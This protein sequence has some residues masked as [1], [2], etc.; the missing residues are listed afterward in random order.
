MAS[1]KDTLF[2]TQEISTQTPILLIDASGSTMF[3]KFDNVIILDK[4]KEIIKNNLP[5][6]QFRIIWWNSNTDNSNNSKFTNGLCIIPFIVKKSTLDQTFA[7]IKPSIS[8]SCLTFPH[9][10]FTSIPNDWISSTNQ[11]KVYFITD[12]EMGYGNISYSELNSL[13][14]NLSNSI[15]NLFEKYNTVQ[16]TI[17]T[18]EP[19]NTNFT[20]IESL[21]SAAGCDVY[22]VIMNNKLTNYV[23]KFVSYTPNNLNGFVHINKNIPP[24]GH[25]PYEDKYFSELRVGDFIK[26]L[27]DKIILNKTSDDELLKIVQLLSTTI[28]YL[29]K[30]KPKNVKNDIV[31]TFCNLFYDTSLDIMLVKFIVSDSVTKESEGSANV[32]ASYRAKLQDLYKQATQLLLTD[33][34]KS[35]G[36]NEHFITLPIMNNANNMSNNTNNNMK[37]ISGHCRMV[38][39]Q[40]T[41]NNQT[42]PNS[43]I[44][45]N[46]ICL[47]VLPFIKCYGTNNSNNN[48]TQSLMSQQ[49]LRQWVRVIISKTYNVGILEDSIIYIVLGMVLLI[50]LSNVPENIK[51]CYRYL[52]HVMLR[53]K[54]VNTDITELE[55]LER[56]ELPVPNS[57]KIEGFYIFMDQVIKI[58]GITS[59][60]ISKL[61]LWYLIC[62]ALN[63][64]KLIK[65]QYM[66]C[67]TD[68]DKDFSNFNTDYLK[69]AN[70]ILQIPNILGIIEY[71]EIPQEIV[72][73]YNC[74]ITLED[75]S[76]T[77][78]YL[79]KSHKSVVNTVCNPI[80]I[81]SQE[82]KDLL[83]QTINTSI[84]PICY[85]KL[86]AES[87]EK[88][89]PKPTIDMNNILDPL[90]TMNIFDSNPN[91]SK[92][93]S[94]KSN[95]S[96]SNDSKSNDNYK[97]SVSAYNK[98]SNNTYSNVYKPEVV[99][100]DN[101]R[102]GKL[103]IL[104]GVVGC[105][106]TTIANK[107]RVECEK[108][109]ITYFTEG[110]DKYC[111]N[112]DTIQEAVNKIKQNLRE[113][114]KLDPDT[115]IVVCIDSCGEHI[116]S[117]TTNIFDVNFGSWKKYNIWVNLDRFYIDNYLA[118]SLRNVLKRGKADEHSNFWLS[119]LNSSN[120]LNSL[121]TCIS[122]HEKKAAALFGKKKSKV[123]FGSNRGSIEEVIS[124][125]NNNADMYSKHIENR[126]DDDQQIQKILE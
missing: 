66:H 60:K 62:L 97:S 76:I 2:L 121:N 109:G 123:V 12:G 84:C 126:V 3:N 19:K 87:F 37:I 70:S 23:S 105:G 82:G 31:N 96:K 9:L 69:H 51:E 36:I 35:I 39:T 114:N 107:L 73:D 65:N 94:F 72:L 58:L 85:T 6:E 120:T 42:Y 49:C 5:E 67:K 88:V 64:E 52:G 122:V 125:L 45:I 20:Q 124:Q 102:N 98:P 43:A 11:T 54:R 74:L 86:T 46:N 48:Y 95:N 116:T 83:L 108:R 110:V 1:T 93:N 22:N 15:K 71:V 59:D 50:V 38:N 55:R 32:F 29:T 79:I 57:G 100:L 68:L 78:G 113:I 118:W 104:K 80:Y 103:V 111:K 40:I 33:V 77:G 34:K 99:K 28:C 90:T 16:L 4:I 8:Q 89:G 10:A 7:F 14:T 24:P 56:G 61:S 101:K 63:N 21:I 41:V 18:V 112:G 91:N 13:K 92:L 47:P 115:K 26:F 30:D 27:S 106:K 17:I 81:L 117:N 53:K 44:K 119:P 75:T 25:I